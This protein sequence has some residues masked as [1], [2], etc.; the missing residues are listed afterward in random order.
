VDDVDALV[1]AVEQVAGSSSDELARLRKEGRR[2]AE[3]SSYPGL[4]PRWRALLDGFV[5][6]GAE[7]R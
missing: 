3:E 2:T 1:A 7:T 6:L 4:R 5:A